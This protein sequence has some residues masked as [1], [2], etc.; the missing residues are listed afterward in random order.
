MGMVGDFYKNYETNR[1][2]GKAVHEMVRLD[3]FGQLDEKTLS[4]GLLN[5]WAGWRKFREDF[6]HLVPIKKFVERPIFHPV[7]LYAG[8]PDLP[9][10]T[11][12][13]HGS[14][15]YL[16]DL[17]T[18]TSKYQHTWEMQTAS[19]VEPLKIW[20]GVPYARFK[21]RVLWLSA[22]EPKYEIIP[23]DKPGAFS[24]FIGALT[25]YKWLIREKGLCK[26]VNA[27]AQEDS[28]E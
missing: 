10:Q 25:A 13:R 1:V 23:L 28:W 2:F 4:E 6:K 17:K 19:Y 27:V 5:T 3:I 22:D 20:M 24:A 12:E 11:A 7:Y 15:F 21:R 8:T 9:M 18:S 26:N 14:E 16:F